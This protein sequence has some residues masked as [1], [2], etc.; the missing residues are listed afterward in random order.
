MPDDRRFDP[1]QDID[2]F[3]AQEDA[4]YNWLIPGLMEFGDRL[5]LT[6]GEGKGKSTAIRQFGLQLAAGQKPFI[7]GDIEP[8]HVLVIDLENS[9]R[10]SRRALKPL[11]ELV[12]LDPRFFQI[13]CWQHGID[14][15]NP[16]DAIIVSAFLR[17]VLPD[18]LIIGPMYKLAPDLRDE[19]VSGQVARQLDEWRQAFGFGLI[20]ESHQPHQVV[21]EDGRWRPER[22]FGSSLWLRWPEFGLC[23]EDGGVLRNWRGPRD[24]RDWPERLYWGKHWPWEAGGDPVC[25]LPGCDRPLQQGQMK[26]CSTAHGQQHRQQQYRARHKE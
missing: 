2:T 6:G 10:Q 5:I 16:Q 7:G 19:T 26:Y 24:E 11:R 14:L 9:D 18:L 12:Q 25:I 21:T 8:R 13:T 15:T 4:D 17:A 3:L 23:L 20:M 22:P 1:P